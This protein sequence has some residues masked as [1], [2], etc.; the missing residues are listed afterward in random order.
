MGKTRNLL[1]G[2]QLAAT[3]HRFFPPNGERYASLWKVFGSE[4]DDVSDSSGA[5][6]P[7]IFEMWDRMIYVSEARHGAP[8]EMWATWQ[9]AHRVSPDVFSF[10][11]SFSRS[12]SAAE[13]SRKKNRACLRVSTET[14]A[15]SP[16]D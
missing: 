10:S 2:R 5:W 1:A 11:G 9:R 7:H 15:A 8:K 13:F 14:S 4:W 3:T 6:A 12:D 16:A